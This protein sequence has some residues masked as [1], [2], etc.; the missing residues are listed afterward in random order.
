MEVE[1]RVITLASTPVSIPDTPV[2]GE[3]VTSTPT[4]EVAG[5]VV[6][7]ASATIP[8]TP[9]IEV[10]GVESGSTVPVMVVVGVVGVG[11]TLG[12]ITTSRRRRTSNLN[13]RQRLWEASRQRHREA[14]LPPKPRQS[15]GGRHQRRMVVLLPTCSR[16]QRHNREQRQCLRVCREQMMPLAHQVLE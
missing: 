6:M 10:W 11:K 2:E 8:S 12:G 5:T 16:G 15:R 7:E 4:A 14:I 9:A 13:S 3:A 1:E